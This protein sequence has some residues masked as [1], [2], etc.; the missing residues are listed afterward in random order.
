MGKYNF[1]DAIREL[2]NMFSTPEFKSHIAQMPLVYIANGASMLA[3]AMQGLGAAKLARFRWLDKQPVFRKQ[4]QEALRIN[5]NRI[6]KTTVIATSPDEVLDLASRYNLNFGDPKEAWMTHTP[7]IVKVP[8]S[9]NSATLRR[10]ER[11]LQEQ[12]KTDLVNVPRDENNTV[13]LPAMQHELGHV[14]DFGEGKAQQDM[15]Q[16]PAKHV[17]ELFTGIATPDDTALGRMEVR[18]WENARVPAGHPMREAALDTYRHVHRYRL[19]Q[20]IAQAF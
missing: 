3:A 12:V 6:P 5:A 4:V 9:E 2:K 13:N 7:K 15:M 8:G 10:L 11:H 14:Q 20:M 18:A 16:P 1:K 19:A 17:K